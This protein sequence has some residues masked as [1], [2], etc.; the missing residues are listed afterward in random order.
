M[1]LSRRTTNERP[2]LAKGGSKEEIQTLQR[3]KW[4]NRQ[5]STV[6]AHT[7]GMSSASLIHLRMKVQRTG[8]KEATRLETRGTTP[9]AIVRRKGIERV[10]N[11][12][13]YEN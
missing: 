2:D 3:R 6:K 5:G 9:T 12:K 8:R 1:N 7:M 13:M 10:A 4:T 11:I